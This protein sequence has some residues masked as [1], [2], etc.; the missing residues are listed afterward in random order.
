MFFET[1]LNRPSA[2]P[3]PYLHLP[4]FI[5]STKFFIITHNVITQFMCLWFDFIACVK[6]VGCYQHM[7]RISFNLNFRNIFTWKFVM[8]SI[9][10]YI[11]KT[12][13]SSASLHI[14]RYVTC[15]GEQETLGKDWIQTH[16][17][18]HAVRVD[19]FEATAV[20]ALLHISLGALRVVPA[21]LQQV[22]LEHS[23]RR[24]MKHYICHHLSVFSH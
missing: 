1:P 12:E 5:F 21:H 3:E 7:V 19:M 11:K 9:L 17:I 18:T 16:S 6:W 22:I 4:F 8:C 23:V 14:L 13:P 10:L 2:G 20:E 24:N 15:N